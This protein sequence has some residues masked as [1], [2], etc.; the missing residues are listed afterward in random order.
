[1]PNW[2]KAHEQ[3]PKN[4][5]MPMQI[6]KLAVALILILPIVSGAEPS[7]AAELWQAEY[8]TD[9]VIGAT[10][11]EVI[12]SGEQ[13]EATLQLSET[14]FDVRYQICTIHP[15]PTPE[16]GFGWACLEGNQ[17][18]FRDG[19]NWTL[20]TARIP[21]FSQTRDNVLFFDEG[22][23]FGVQF[24]IYENETTDYQTVL[25]FPR[26]AE[27][28]YTAENSVYA[29]CQESHYF[30]TNVVAGEKQAPGLGFLALLVVIALVMKRE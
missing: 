12:V 11:P 6:V 26:G 2:E 14:V 1:L 23:R 17:P 25:D 3:S 30:G 21:E 4:R 18:A 19:N 27:C 15:N 16:N 24:F 13:F 29:V 20:S 5:E 8:G 10:F 28:D 9:L 7:E 22:N